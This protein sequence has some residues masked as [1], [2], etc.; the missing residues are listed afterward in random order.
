MSSAGD[1]VFFVVT[2]DSC[3]ERRQRGGISGS[4]RARTERGERERKKEMERFQDH[5]RS[6]TSVHPSERRSVVQPALA[7]KPRI[8][9]ARSSSLGF[10]G[11]ASFAH[12]P[13]PR[14]SRPRPR[15]F[16][17]RD[18]DAIPRVRGRRSASHYARSKLRVEETRTPMRV[19]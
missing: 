13:I 2:R 15:A 17:R 9:P 12:V 10:S 8:R 14:R 5:G 1:N 6:L 7:Q 3:L 4:A 18:G 19:S 16:G 11:F